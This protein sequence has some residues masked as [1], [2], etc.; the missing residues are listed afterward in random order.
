MANTQSPIARVLIS[1]RPLFSFGWRAIAILSIC[2]AIFIAWQWQRVIEADMLVSVIVQG[3]RFDLVLVGLALAIPV[4]CFPLLASNRLLVPAWRGLLKIYLSAILLLVVFMECSTPSFVDQFDSRPNIL[5]LEYLNHPREV[6]ATLWAAYKVPI[7]VTIL[8][9]SALTWINVRQIGRLVKP[10]QP[11]G[12]VPA[13]LAMP[14]LL[15]ACLGMI[16]STLDH[17]PVNPSTVSL[18]SDPMVNEIALNSTYTVLY[19]LSETIH[20]PEGGFRYGHLDD[21]V[22]VD[23]VRHAMGIRM[24]AFT[25]DSLPTLHIQNLRRPVPDLMNL[26][27]I[28]EESLGAEFVGSLGGRD[29]TPNLDELSHEGIWFSN[30]YATGT[31]SVRGLEAIVT[32]F[33]P[34]PARS[35]VKLGKSQRD[36]F[37]LAQLLGQLDYE[38]SFIYGGESQFDNMRRFFMNNG[39]DKVIDEKDYDDPVFVGSWGVSDEDLFKRAHAE[40]SAAGGKPFFGLVFTSSNH[41][42][43]QFPDGRIELVDQEKNTVN[44]AVKYADYALGQFIRVAKESDYWDDTVFLIVADH[45]SRVYGNEALPV[46]RFHIPGLILGGSIRPKVFDPV[47]SQID[48]PPTLLSLIGVSAEHPMIG[49]D[50]TLPDAQVSPGRAIMQFNGTQAYMDGDRVA[51]LQKDMPIQQFTYEQ[52]RL[53]PVTGVSPGLSTKALAHASWSSMAYEQALYRLPAAE[54]QTK[55]GKSRS[56]TGYRP[57]SVEGFRR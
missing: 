34:T 21:N 4:L 2:R 8:L 56:A 17:R 44:N 15:L 39:F 30:L 27:I 40:F 37:T 52:G 57:D 23:E 42:P 1:L 14:F 48:L 46:R 24:D 10:I 12:F 5:F 7:A 35:V 47:A 22:I 53:T 41:T 19:A 28:V 45:N 43:F 33:T 6:A 51:I 9:V 38:S 29:L 55:A 36:F 20:E 50:L 31:R 11:V 26:V 32:G 18:S 13:I 54:R 16:R 25:N 49:H 3:L